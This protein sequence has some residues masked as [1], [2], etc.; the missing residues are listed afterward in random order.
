MWHFSLE[1]LLGLVVFATV[2]SITPGP[3]N[4]MLMASGLNYG[5]RRSLSH[6]LGISI[7]FG[8]MVL[9][10]GLGAQS[11][12]ERY[13]LLHVLMKY[14][15]AVYLCWLAFRIAAAPTDGVGGPSTNTAKPFTFFQAAAFQW[16]NPKAWVMAVAALTAYLP[17]PSGTADVVL[18]SGVF[19][20]VNLPCVGAWAG[21]GVMLRRI[22]S[23]PRR[24]R[25]F[26][27]VTALLLLMSIFPILTT[28]VP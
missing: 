12:F 23:Q 4:L 14:A 10:I 24:M 9:I 13:P 26:N 16:V 22:L 3:N 8:A 21:F 1:L 25:M 2:T 28:Q 27:R 18:L 6:L 20:L 7:G 11:L 17:Q 19:M 15:G 5:F